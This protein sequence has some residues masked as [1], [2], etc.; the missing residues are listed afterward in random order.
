MF[1]RVLKWICFSGVVSLFPLC[2]SAIAMMMHTRYHN[3]YALYERGELMLIAATLLTTAA[4]DM[5]FSGTHRLKTKIFV[6]V[7]TLA[8]LIG[9]WISYAIVL[10]CIISNQPYNR[11]ALLVVSP[12]AFG[13]ALAAG[14]ACVMLSEEPP[15]PLS[16]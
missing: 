16:P 10:D 6:G 9:A 7:I 11:D 2:A 5:I 8:M 4:G 3:H 13:I 14:L 15:P 1:A 12:W